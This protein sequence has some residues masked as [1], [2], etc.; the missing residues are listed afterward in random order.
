MEP[1]R[2]KP[3]SGW[4][5]ALTATI[6][7]VEITWRAGGK[8]AVDKWLAKHECSTVTPDVSAVCGGPFGGVLEFVVC[9]TT[10]GTFV[11]AQCGF[12]GAR[13]E[14]LTNLTENF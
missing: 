10:V 11:H 13:M 6:A 14:D 4:L 2:D 5:E 1:E 7:S 8:E 12:C 9:P 3:E